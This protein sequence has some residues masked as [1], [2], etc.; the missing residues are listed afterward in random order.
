MQKFNTDLRQ[1]LKWM[2]NKAPNIQALIESKAEWHERYSNMFWSDWERDVFNLDTV[3]EFGVYVWCEILG[4]PKSKF[5]FESLTRAWAY[6]NQRQNYVYSGTNTSI[7]ESDR[8]LIG[9]NFFGAGDDVITAL[10]E[11]RIILKLRYMTLISD[12]RPNSINEMFRYIFN[13]GAEW[14]YAAKQFAYVM[15]S[16]AEPNGPDA[17]NTLTFSLTDWRG[18]W[19]TSTTPRQQ[20]GQDNVNSVPSTSGTGKWRISFNSGSGSSITSVTAPDGSANRAWEVRFPNPYSNISDTMRPTI[21]TTASQVTPNGPNQV[22]IQSVYVKPDMTATGLKQY[23]IDGA[24]KINTSSPAPVTWYKVNQR[25]C[26][27]FTNGDPVV[28][29]SGVLTGFGAAYSTDSKY[30]GW[31]NV[32]NGW[33][34]IWNATVTSGDHKAIQYMQ[35]LQ[36]LGF[37]IGYFQNVAE[38]LPGKAYTY[39]GFMLEKR[40]DTGRPQT[41]GIFFYTTQN[42]NTAYNQT[43]YVLNTAGTQVTFAASAAG[44]SIVLNGVPVMVS[45]DWLGEPINPAYQIGTGDGTTR[46]F[47]ITAPPNYVPPVNLPMTLKYKIGRGFTLS[48]QFINLISDRKMGIL[49]ANAG[50]PNI[51]VY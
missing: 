19:A 17:F 38:T 36:G 51:I 13:N 22:F 42:R 11:A 25:A 26:F 3:N 6:G 31:Q 18:T 47:N 12:G 10:F 2:H 43:D 8:N 32:G 39:F 48:P 50:I 27:D 9:G 45:G 24:I 5:I 23:V 14:N 46:A 28:T 20:I 44:G 34:R 40:D 49:P 16:T 37:G 15:D 29:V 7:P 35:I 30:A 41:P 4:I 21:T 33:Y 1:V